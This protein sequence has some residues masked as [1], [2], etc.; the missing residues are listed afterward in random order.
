MEPTAQTS[1]IWISDGRTGCA[2]V[3]S[4]QST[5]V[6]ND[7]HALGSSVHPVTSGAPVA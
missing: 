6:D 1:W 5:S 2:Y 7:A 4:S 3:S